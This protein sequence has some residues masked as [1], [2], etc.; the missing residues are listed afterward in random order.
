MSLKA[1]RAGSPS[2]IGES[3]RAACWLTAS[4]APS[5]RR[6]PRSS[7]GSHTSADAALQLIQTHDLQAEDIAAIVLHNGPAEFPFLSSPIERKRHP[8][9][10]VEAQF[11]I[12]WVVAA[13]FVDRKVSIAQF[14][15]SA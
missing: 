13:A 7:R 9:T 6:R 15:P 11:S 4:R 5:R 1:K 2:T 12:P 10:N 8:E 3:I 14:T